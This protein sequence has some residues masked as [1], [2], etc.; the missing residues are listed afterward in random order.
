[1]PFPAAFKSDRLIAVSGAVLAVALALGLR[2]SSPAVAQNASAPQAGEMRIAT[3]DVLLLAERLVA[4]DRYR[5]GRETN[6]ASLSK[7]LQAMLD[8]LKALEARYSSLAADSPERAA[9][10]EAYQQKSQAFQKS[11]QEAQVNDERFKATQVGEAYRLVVT[12]ADQIG[13]ELGYTLVL[14]SRA[15]VPDVRSD[16]VPGAVQEMLARPVLRAPAADDLTER[17]AAKLGLLPEPVKAVP[18]TDP[19]AP[20]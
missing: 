10:Q 5:S 7:P 8:E 1:M 11:Q 17:V 18:L 14:A 9:I 16:N 19:A 4:S 12:A 3:V 2:D 13:Q 6:A 20:K 15:G